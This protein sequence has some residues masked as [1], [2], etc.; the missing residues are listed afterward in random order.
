MDDRERLEPEDEDEF[1]E[2]Y[3]EAIEPSVRVEVA[4]LSVYAHIGVEEAERTV[5]H[6]LVLDLSFELDRCDALVTDRI[7]DTVDYSD[8]SQQVYLIAQERSYNTLE[9]LCSVVADRMLERYD[10]QSVTVRAA[11]PDP[12]MPLPVEEVA[13]EVTKDRA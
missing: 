12:P 2:D 5:G 10:A 7:D 8:A 11:K 4:G 13:V 6:R 1:Q 9:R 3:E